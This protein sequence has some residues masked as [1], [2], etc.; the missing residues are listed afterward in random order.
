MPFFVRWPGKVSP[1]TKN[2][3]LV[4]LTDLMATCA[5]IIG[6]EIPEN[7]G[8][9]SFSI[10]PLLLGKKNDYKHRAVV[11]HSAPGK[12]SIRE[13]NWKLE[14]CPGSGGLWTSPTDEK[15]RELGLPEIQLYN[16][17]ADEGEKDNVYK[18][19]PEIVNKLTIELMPPVGA[20][21]I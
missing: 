9:D 19:Y 1:G 10:L 6:S 3:E 21:R 2:E 15:A 11:H 12:F 4:C 20:T 14:F 16:L 5:E 8:E 13:G 7:A 18:K 17:E